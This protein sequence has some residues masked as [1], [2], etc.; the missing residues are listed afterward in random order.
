MLT[1][2]QIQAALKTC[3]SEVVLNDGAGGKG[4]GS[5]VLVVRRRA[6]GC[7][8][9]WSGQWWDDG[10]RRRKPLGPY[11]SVGLAAARQLYA[12]QV[13]DVLA[14]GRNPLVAVL[15]ADKPTV[16]RLFTAYCDRM[17]ADGK[18]SEPEYRRCLEAAAAAF[19]ANRLAGDILPDDVSA[20]LAKVFARARSQADHERA[21]LHAAFQWGLR[22]AHDYRQDL[23]VDW[24]V[25][26]NPVGAIPKDTAASRPRDRAL[27]PD[28]LAAVWHGLAGSRMGLEAATCVRMLILTGQ[29]VREVLRMDR[30][31]ID[32][33]RMLWTMPAMSTKGGLQ[34][35][36]A[37]AHVIP[38]PELARPVLQQLMAANKS[39]PLFANRKGEPM[40]D[41]SIRQALVDLQTDLA[42]DPFQPRDLRRTWKTRT[43][44]AG[45]ARFERDLI[46]QHQQGD[47]GS[48]HY[49]MATYTP[50]LRAAMDTWNDWLEQLIAGKQSRA[51]LT[52]A[53]ALQA[54]AQA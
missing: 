46:Q 5:L 17:L 14:A 44:D 53:G 36:R 1:D 8:A 13:R 40:A 2:R 37:T 52:H 32:L 25:R 29:R 43:A 50:Q 20:Y 33:A 51:A 39:G 45:I 18:S 38:L 47:T 9:N 41:N 48:K 49:D 11:P 54:Q 10:K 35:K 12:D 26:Q 7:T 15:T 16:A 6:D 34:G 19:G 4:G 31:H 28:E 42:M 30:R 27:T 3:T 23:R 22:A 21:Y 24:G